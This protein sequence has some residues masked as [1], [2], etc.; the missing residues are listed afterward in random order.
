MTVFPRGSRSIPVTIDRR[1][2]FRKV[3]NLWFFILQPANPEVLPMTPLEAFKKLQQEMQLTPEKA[4]T[5][6]AAIR[7]A[8]R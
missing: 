7:D 4:E 8:R 2:Q 1:D 6:K 3:L 5:W